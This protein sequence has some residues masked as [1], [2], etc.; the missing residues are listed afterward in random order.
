MGA[1]K[2]QSKKRDTSSSNAPARTMEEL[3]AKTGHQIHSFSRGEKVEGKVIEVGP[4]SLILDIG[5]K[6]EGLIVDREFEAAKHLIKTLNPGDVIKA[7]VLV[8]E[9]R[10][11]ILLSLRNTAEDYAWKL[12]EEAQ[13]NSQEVEAKVES[14]SRGGLAVNV[15][16]LNGFIPGS[17][18]GSSLAKN[19]GSA[20][21]RGLKV[22]VI[23]LDKEKTRV[24]LSEKAVSEAEALAAQ[25]EVLKKI[26]S[27]E[28][29]RGKVVGLAGFGAFVQIEKDKVPI[30]G[31]VHLSELSWQKVA[32]PSEIVKAG[33]EVEV[34][35][36]GKDPSAGSGHGGGRLAFSIKKA[37]EDP[38]NDIQEKYKEDSRVQGTVSKVGD[39]GAIVILEPGIEGLLH[40]SKVPADVSL[41]VGSQVECFVEKADKKAR[42]ISL[43]LVLKTKPI[44]YK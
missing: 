44:G 38:W 29:F 43:G 1:I 34:T 6:S 35:V 42:K 23:E 40:I 9:E 33:D 10:G 26:K 25:E 11:Q 41:K 27:G 16:G 8:P 3:L 14:Y 17:H 21:G 7:Q 32:D 20:V 28:K 31:L 39:F 18:F 4:K 19:P 12:L 36:I 13:K 24:V 37:Q 5:A 30:D 15:F 22:K 2:K